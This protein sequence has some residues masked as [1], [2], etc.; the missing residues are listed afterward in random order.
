[1]KIKKQF[2]EPFIGTS[3]VNNLTL[4]HSVNGNYSVIIAI[5]NTSMQYGSNP[6]TYLSYHT[7][8]GQI[9]KLLADNYILQ[10]T[11]IVAVKKYRNDNDKK[12]YL[13]EKY[14]AHFENRKYHDVQTYLTITKQ[15]KKTRFFTYSDKE[16]KDFC[17]TILKVI[18][19]LQGYGVAT[20]LLDESMI[21]NLLISFLA[22]DFSGENVVMSNISCDKHGLEFGDNHLRAITIVDPE[23]MNLAN[24]M[25]TFKPADGAIS[26]YPSDNFSFLLNIP[27]AHTVLYNQ[28]VFI[29]DQLKIKKD[30]ELKK[31]RHSSL[32]YSHARS[33]KPVIGQRY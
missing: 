25:A 24:S 33:R 31:K 6:D 27:D 26:N 14:F 11:D 13:S 20:Q 17:N 19:T 22:F 5:E 29:P 23:Q 18:D 2:K 12:D 1:M 10:K 7:C 3:V 8:F 16:V 9:I 4:L 15:N 32:T 30:L 21:N 28:A